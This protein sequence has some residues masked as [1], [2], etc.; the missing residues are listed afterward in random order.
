M[1]LG[2][3]EIDIE[4]FRYRRKRDRYFVLSLEI[5]VSGW[6]CDGLFV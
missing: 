2:Y 4:G 1:I 3:R 5:V 6:L